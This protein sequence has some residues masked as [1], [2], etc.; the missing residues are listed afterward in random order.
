MEEKRKSGEIG[1]VHYM[2]MDTGAE[3]PKTYEFIKKC[4][5]YFDIDLT[6]IRAD[7]KLDGYGRGFGTTYKV[8]SLDECKHDLKPWYDYTKKYG[9]PNVS[10]PKCTGEMKTRPHDKYCN[11]VFGKNNYVTWLG[12]RADEQRRI[13]DAKNIRYLAEIS[14]MGKEDIIDWWSDMP[15]D[16]EIPEWL[17]NCV[18]CIKKGANKIA[19]AQRDEP[20]LAVLWQDLITRDGCHVTPAKAKL[21]VPQDAAYRNWQTFS[22]IEEAFKDFSRD[23]IIG[24][25]R[26]S[27]GGCT[28]SCE[29]FGCQV[30]FIDDE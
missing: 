15:F 4:V 11:K 1:K 2:F 14:D 24:G 6:C 26:S 13:K 12:I 22:G 17:G 7:V 25:M 8:V 16:L 23:E 21:D 10:T 27:A 3:H 5:D 19:L 18:F 9:I 30:D 29:V 20:E 28:E